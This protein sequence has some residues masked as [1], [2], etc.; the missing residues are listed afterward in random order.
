MNALLQNL[1]DAARVLIHG[2]AEP[3]SSEEDEPP[4]GPEESAYQT[5]LDSWRTAISW[6]IGGLAAAATVMLAGTQISS[7]GTMSASDGAR[8]WIALGGVTSAVAGVLWLLFLF[9][10]LKKPVVAD[11]HDL[12]ELTR[13]RPDKVQA[14]VLE[15]VDFDTSLNMGTADF[16]ALW[17]ALEDAR[18]VYY[19]TLDDLHAAKI[20]ASG[21]SDPETSAPLAAE[22]ERLEKLR[23]VN[24]TQLRRFHTGAQRVTDRLQYQRTRARFSRGAW[25]AFGGSTLAA[26]GICA[27]AWAV[28]PTAPGQES[29]AA[30]PQSPTAAVLQLNEAGFETYGY[31]L[32]D[33]C[34]EDAREDGI[35][36]IAL[37][38]EDDAWEIVTVPSD[39]CP[40]PV[41]LTV[42]TDQGNVEAI[43]QAA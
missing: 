28:N 19:S 14:T 35:P 23:K 31:L 17:T 32:E 2:L 8:F 42:A 1:R 40:G 27:F 13:P 9:Y 6:L 7:V 12:H 26:I 25:L 30:A 18:A 41:R 16:K 15:L 29:S 10:T 33:S 38:R 39:V 20:A 21:A 36:V 4:Q 11:F 37:S 5:G 3:K 24:E 43:D 34:A 22:V